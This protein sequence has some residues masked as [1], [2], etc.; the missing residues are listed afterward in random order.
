MSSRVE[1]AVLLYSMLLLSHFLLN[2]YF[3][4]HR[5][6][7]RSFFLR[8]AKSILRCII[9]QSGR[10]KDWK[11]SPKWTIIINIHNTAKAQKRLWGKI[12]WKN[13]NQRNKE[14]CNGMLTSDITKVQPWIPTSWSYLNMLYTRT[15]Q[16][17]C[18]NA[19][20]FMPHSLLRSYWQVIAPRKVEL[21]SK[22]C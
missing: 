7:Q 5:H 16:P 15:R 11:M 10:I 9:C 18:I 3:Y 21:P 19:M 8:W 12:G 6:S 17:N 20:L 14:E 1:L 2:S 13:I 22:E 4:I